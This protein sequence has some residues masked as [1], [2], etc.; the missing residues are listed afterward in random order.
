MPTSQSH[1][2]KILSTIVIGV[3]LFG[4][5]VGLVHFF[6]SWTY[7][8][9]EKKS[10]HIGVDV[11]LPEVSVDRLRSTV[12]RLSSVGS[13]VTGYPGAKASADFLESEF[14]RLEMQDVHLEAFSVTV[15]VDK[16][17]SLRLLKSGEEIPLR[18]VWP[19]LVRTPTT[20]GV[21][22][23]LIYVGDGEFSG[24]DGHDVSGNVVLMDFNS[25][26]R[27]IN[28]GILGAGAVVFIAPKSTT[29]GQAE[30]KFA[31]VPV[32]MPRFYVDREAGERLRG[33]AGEGLEVEV[34]GRMDWEVRDG[35]NVV[36]TFP[37]S[38]PDLRDQEV[39]LS[40]YYDGMSV[41]PSLAPAAEMACGIAGLLE[42][43]EML[44]VHPPA[45]TVLFLAT[46]GH[47]QNLRGIDAYMQRHSRKKE[48][49]LEDVTKPVF[50]KLFLGLDLSSGN[51]GL[52][53][54]DTREKMGAT[55]FSRA[56]NFFGVSLG[57]RLA[58]MAEGVAA[59]MGRELEDVFANVIA[60]QQSDKAW[61]ILIPGR[62]LPIESEYALACGTPAVSLIT[63]Y[64]ARLGVDSPLD[65]IEGVNFGNLRTQVVF[66]GGL[67]S[68]VLNKEDALGDV[69]NLEMKDDSWG[70]EGRVKGFS[71]Y[72]ITPDIEMGGAIVAVRSGRE[73]KSAKGVRG[74][75]FELANKQ[76]IFKV[77]RIFREYWPLEIHPFLQNP[78]TGEI[79]H[80]PDRG[81]DYPIEVKTKWGLEKPLVVLFRC[82]PTSFYETVDP[83]QL[84]RLSDIVVMD[85]GN[86]VPQHYGY[87]F[88]TARSHYREEEPTIGVVFTEPGKRVKLTLS[89]G[90]FGVRFFLVNADPEG[91][92]GAGFLT[93]VPS[94]FEQTAYKAALDM[95]RVD[96]GRIRELLSYGIENTRLTALH[97]KAEAHLREAE[98]ALKERRWSGFIQNARAAQGV[99]ARAYPDVKGTQNDVIRGVVFFMAMLIPCSFFAE[100]LVFAFADIRKQIAGFFG[101]FFFVWF[102]L[103]VVHPAFSLANPALVL[104]AFLI[105]A[106]ATFVL[107]LISSR[108][109][110]QMRALRTDAAVAHGTD[111]GRGSAFYVA[112]ML[113]ISNMRR[114]K[115]RTSLTLL[116]V[117][118][119]T[120]TVMS[121]TS[122]K[123]VLRHMRIPWTEGPFRA[124]AM[125]RDG[126][127]KELDDSVLE[128]TS[129]EFRDIGR[130]V[131]RAWYTKATKIQGGGLAV[132]AAS[133]VGM[134]PEERLITGIDSCLSAGRWIAGNAECVI[135]DSMAV[136]LG[137]TVE[138][139][140]RS[141]VRVF[142]RELEVVGIMDS[143]RLKGLKDL[144][145]APLTPVDFGVVP[146]DV[147]AE[148]L[149]QGSISLRAAQQQAGR[150]AGSTVGIHVYKHLNPGRVVFLP[151]HLMREMGR[152]G[153]WLGGT[154]GDLRS[155]AVGFDEGIDVGK[156]VESF[157]SRLELTVFGSIP[158]ESGPSEVYVFS[159]HGMASV[160]GLGILVIPIAIAALIVLNTMMGAV[161]ERFR[162]IG[163][164]SSVGLAPSH[165][166]MLFMA[167][168]CV[169]A[170]IGAVGGYLV[171]QGVGRVLF[172]SGLLHG[173]SLNYS[174]L[175]A[176]MAMGLVMSVVM[177]STLYPSKKASQ[178]AVPDVTRRWELTDPEGDHWRFEFP[179][180]VSSRDVRGMFSFL[181]T[182]FRAYSRYSLGEFYAD[183]VSF[184]EEETPE[185]PSYTIQ[186]QTWLA[187]FDM[188][189]SQETVLRATPTGRY[190]IY[191]IEMVLDRMSGE[192]QAWIRTNRQFL[193]LL[194]KQFLIWRTL[195]DQ[196]R[197]EY[198]QK[199]DSDRDRIVEA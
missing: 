117:L 142:G 193:T 113:G 135:P 3:V 27:W 167:E 128:Y 47:C 34:K 138:D 39:M 106:L 170:V 59:G 7:R 23:S 35:Y 83:R 121:F 55:Q 80:A 178:M 182:Y 90:L 43:G 199:A 103:S 179:F 159:S 194:R 147:L 26:G 174:S 155:V 4:V 136:D 132:E 64:D 12:A 114:R 77:T 92:D 122:L 111:I 180:T 133:V 1:F 196:V 57:R 67:I 108:F 48:P 102:C 140:G 166:G 20:L 100:R 78:V 134:V 154:T 171:A 124:G 82:V 46:S 112:F 101:F 162:D 126:A 10:A 18:C 54:W 144:D 14:R 56:K 127:W 137:L 76:G 95:W 181:T 157:V 19:N 141:T 22:G 161:Y 105:L 73:S 68:Q 115:L 107:K 93:K 143:E 152:V 53:A 65:R 51:D 88:E 110:A 2:P 109:S 131:P 79:T 36:G 81:A 63:S 60:S 125:I 150:T 183:G 118:L 160:S 98:E 153:H 37:G 119:L 173:L 52:A 89:T 187:P 9:A 24:F 49:F 50:P 61:G 156:V 120:F 41:V 191:E 42:L 164:Y 84:G 17:A 21:R 87:F 85:A 72:A 86:S 44:R 29:T 192:L 97:D 176:V 28:A 129:D 70:V 38:D 94:A 186:M 198:A 40:A 66:I 8:P 175:S 185:G 151:Y 169:Y 6:R 11:F 71:R 139:V 30:G 96:D 149:Q 62:P 146:E 16:G 130:V 189:V 195:S 148:Q 13:R 31:E 163:I 188:G 197:D 5:L 104:V 15:P 190:G 75:F 145:G 177:L 123:F 184:R 116:T 172:E 99:E 74:E 33:L 158:Q 58:S 165:I 25:G 69:L 32:A 91:G 45:R 168:S